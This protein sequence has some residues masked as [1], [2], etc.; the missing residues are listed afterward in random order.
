MP[1]RD[2]QK[3]T[4]ADQI[5]SS[6]S[7]ESHEPGP[8]EVRRATLLAWEGYLTSVEFMNI[9]NMELSDI[10]KDH[11]KKLMEGWVFFSEENGVRPT[12]RPWSPP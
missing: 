10:N 5:S 2:P 11:V 8:A 9:R 7:Q 1:E 12:P 4:E 3:V 6:W